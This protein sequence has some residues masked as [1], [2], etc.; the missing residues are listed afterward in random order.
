MI[1]TAPKD[2]EEYHYNLR[3]RY[4]SSGELKTVLEAA[5]DRILEVYAIPFLQDMNRLKNLLKQRNDIVE[6]EWS[7]QINDHNDSVWRAKADAAFKS[8]DYTEV[9][10][11]YG[12]IPLERQTK[13]DDSKLRFSEKQTGTSLD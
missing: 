7:Q 2:S 11:C 9:I 10:L 1:H 6:A 12:N 5:K 13:T 8:K 4:Q 3:W